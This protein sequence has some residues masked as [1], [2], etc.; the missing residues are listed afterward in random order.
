M[1]LS[2]NRICLI[3]FFSQVILYILYHSQNINILYI[4]YSVHYVER[5]SVILNFKYNA[6]LCLIH[7]VINTHLWV[8]V[9]CK[10]AIYIYSKK[11]LKLKCIIGQTY[12]LKCF[13]S[14]LLPVIFFFMKSN[15]GTIITYI[16]NSTLLTSLW[17]HV[18]ASSFFTVTRS[19]QLMY[20]HTESSS[21][22]IQNN[23]IYCHICSDILNAVSLCSHIVHICVEHI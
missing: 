11:I 9:H 5:L 18:M 19:T 21:I 8:S 14:M 10:L 2:C 7:K 4:L 22:I 13:I 16:E 15:F 12:K 3:V 20:T 6:I 17:C 1:H 23:F